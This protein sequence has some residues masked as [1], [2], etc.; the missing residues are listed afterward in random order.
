MLNS[1]P[2]QDIRFIDIETVPQY[3]SFLE[4]PENKKKLFKD[5]FSRE[6]E[7]IEEFTP[8]SHDSRVEELYRKNASFLP[9]LGKIVCI[10]V[11]RILP[12]VDG[13]YPIKVASFTGDDD[14]D[15]L[16]KFIS[17]MKEIK[18]CKNPAL[19][20]IHLCAHYGKLFDF[21]FIAKRLILNKLPLPAMFDYG[22]L[23]PWEINYL[24]DTIDAWRFGRMDCNA[25]LDML[26][27]A[28]G[29]E[30]SKSDISGKDVKDIYYKENDLARI[31]M[32]CERD[33][34]ALME[35]YLRMKGDYRELIKSK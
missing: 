21:P 16:I 12:E 20:P 9:E 13:A 26:A 27:D 35:I 28:F 8:E 2:I 1:K 31:S 4:M 33:V 34:V 29:V 17:A 32:Y 15:I 22:H 24:V 6:F 3:E 11:G 19:A 25:S 30:S 10:S 7:A 18:E 5:K 14:K 23:K